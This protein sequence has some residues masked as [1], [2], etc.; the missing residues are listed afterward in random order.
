MAILSASR[1]RQPAAA[2]G[3]EAG[4]KDLRVLAGEP[5]PKGMPAGVAVETRASLGNQ[6]GFFE[7]IH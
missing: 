5:W 4:P 7:S 6:E 3:R 2:S 1:T